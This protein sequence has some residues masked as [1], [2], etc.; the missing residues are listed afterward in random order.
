VQKLGDAP[1]WGDIRAD[2]RYAL[3]SRQI[4]DLLTQIWSAMAHCVKPAFFNA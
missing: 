1:A 2:L 3:S 4:V